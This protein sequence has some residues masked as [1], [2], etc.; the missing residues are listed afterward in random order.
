MRRATD[1]TVRLQRTLQRILFSQ[2]DSLDLFK[3]VD[4]PGVKLIAQLNV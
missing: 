4:F 3:I 1:A 2:F